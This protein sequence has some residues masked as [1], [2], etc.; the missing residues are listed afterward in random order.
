[1]A[2]YR[3]QKG[4][5]ARPQARRDRMAARLAAAPTA[6]DQLAVA[7]DWFRMALSRGAD[8]EAEVLR[9]VREEAQ[10][11]AGIAAEADARAIAAKVVNP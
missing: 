6:W 9:M 5:P 11:L 3:T 8:P 2:G 10:R 1:M 7:F 4:R